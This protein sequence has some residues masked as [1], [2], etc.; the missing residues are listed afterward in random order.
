MLLG[1]SSDEVDLLLSL[2]DVGAVVLEADLVVTRLGSVEAEEIGELGAVLA[3]LVDTVL[4]VLGEGLVEF[5][6]VFL[7][8]G[9]LSEEF[10]ALLDQVLADDLQDLVLLEHLTRDVEWEIL[11]V[12]DT[13]DEV[14]PFGD[15]L[16][17]VVHDEDTSDIELDVVSLLAGLEEIEGSALGDEDDGTELE[18]TFNGEVLDSEVFFPVVRDGLKKKMKGK[19]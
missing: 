14:E 9:D 5:L 15:E 1:L 16:L 11:R 13:T 8:V 6:V 18:L 7:V 12:D 4:E 19:K 2:L 3:V 17:A 10:D